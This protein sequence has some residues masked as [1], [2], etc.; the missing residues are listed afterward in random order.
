MDVILFLVALAFG[1]VGFA[2]GFVLGARRP[3]KEL[4]DW[5]LKEAV[6]QLEANM[7]I[8]GPLWRQIEAIERSLWPP[9]ENV[10]VDKRGPEW[11]YQTRGR[12]G[13]SSTRRNSLRQ[14]EPEP[15]G[16]AEED[17]EK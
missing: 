9:P 5:A 1:L 11:A 10:D 2:A 15:S 3:G 8:E 4:A 6:R 14:H 16:G 12:Y 7:E 13:R 17:E